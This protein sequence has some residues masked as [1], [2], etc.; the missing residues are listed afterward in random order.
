M[1]TLDQVLEA[2]D[3]AESHPDKYL[4][5]TTNWCATVAWHLNKNSSIPELLSKTMEEMQLRHKQE[6]DNLDG[7][8]FH[9]KKCRCGVEGSYPIEITHCVCGTLFVR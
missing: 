6:F 9:Y 8:G 1:I 5:G 3:Y 7:S 4:R 2:Y